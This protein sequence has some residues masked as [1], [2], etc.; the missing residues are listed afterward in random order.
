MSDLLSFNHFS[1]GSQSIF[2]ASTLA[3]ISGLPKQMIGAI[4]QKEEHRSDRYKNLGYVHQG[5]SPVTLQYK[6]FRP[7]HD[8]EVPA[9]ITFTGR[10][11]APPAGVERTS[12]YTDFAQYLQDLPN[13][14]IGVLIARPEDEVFLYLYYKQKWGGGP[15]AGGQ[16]YAII[17]WDRDTKE[18]VD[19]GFVGLTTE[20]VDKTLVRSVHRTKGG[21]TNG[22]VQEYVN[23]LSGGAPRRNKPVLAY[24]FNIEQTGEDLPREKTQS[25][26]KAKEVTSVDLIRVF[27]QRYANLIDNAKVETLRKLREQIRNVSPVQPSQTPAE[28][29]TF[30]TNIG[31]D[32]GQTYAFLYVKMRDFRAKL[33]AE[34]Q[35]A[36][37]KTSGFDLEEEITLGGNITNWSGQYHFNLGEDPKDTRVSRYDRRARRLDSDKVRR[38]IPLS[39]EY[40]D[41]P[42]MI[43]AHTLDNVMHK[44]MF[45]ILTGRIDS[46]AVNVLALLGIDPNSADLEGLPDFEQWT[47]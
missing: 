13:G 42:S 35:G 46:P 22:K 38:Q 39:G 10:K 18:A 29:R 2:E 33:W 17:V 7:S 24:E 5:G 25:R 12:Q 14:P 40:A 19:F 8:I 1:G 3:T 30:A 45:F 43:K 36:Y 20:G 47:L 34:G 26:T 31:E 21:N 28:V 11:V 44:F 41:I 15:N 37:Q 27:A 32:L 23:S 4:H 9:P 16:Q 6:Y